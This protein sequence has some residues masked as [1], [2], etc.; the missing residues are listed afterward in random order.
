MDDIAAAAGVGKGTLYRYFKDKEELYLALLERA[1][2]QVTE[3][4]QEAVSAGSPVEKLERLVA[5]ILSYFEAPPHVFDLVQH[6]EAL[7]T[8]DRPFTW[9]PRQLSIDLTEEVLREGQAA[10]VF[11]V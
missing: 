1:S 7:H 6:A 4:L 2:A 11:S 10:G 9:A 3:L 5:A 8:P